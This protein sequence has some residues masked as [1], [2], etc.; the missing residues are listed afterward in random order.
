[1]ADIGLVQDMMPIPVGGEYEC[2]IP[3]ITERKSASLAEWKA[4]YIDFASQISRNILLRFG[5]QYLSMR[6]I[7]ENLESIF[8]RKLT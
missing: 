3:A 8:G 6:R 4:S 7:K 2:E 5:Y 1:M